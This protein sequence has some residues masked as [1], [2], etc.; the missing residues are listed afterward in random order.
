MQWTLPSSVD[1][2]DNNFANAKL[3]ANHVDGTWFLPTDYMSDT[4]PETTSPGFDILGHDLPRDQLAK[5]QFCANVRL[6]WLVAQK[7]PDEPGLI[8]ADVRVLWPRGL[9]NSPVGGGTD[10]FC[11]SDV[12]GKVNPDNFGVGEQPQYHAIYLTTTIKENTQ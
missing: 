5:A 9:F 12:A 8:R 4:A 7:L 11:T 10:G 2:T 3:L 1:T 6:T